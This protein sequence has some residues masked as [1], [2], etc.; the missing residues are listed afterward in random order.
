MAVFKFT[1]STENATVYVMYTINFQYRQSILKYDLYY[2]IFYY[3]TLY[4]IIVYI[5]M[6]F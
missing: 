4:Y 3:I 2:I 1:V 6:H 5:H